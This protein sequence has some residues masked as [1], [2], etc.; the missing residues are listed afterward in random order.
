VELEY[1]GS[2]VHY[3]LETLAG[4]RLMSRMP[5]STEFLSPGATVTARF[6]P[7]RTVLVPAESKA[8]DA[9][10]PETGGIAK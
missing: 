8:T 10:S 9:W 4:D 5:A 7:D 3:F 2:D 6:A 1:E